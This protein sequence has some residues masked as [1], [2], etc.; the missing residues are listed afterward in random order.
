MLMVV[1]DC[2]PQLVENPVNLAYSVYNLD[3]IQISLVV[4]PP[5]GGGGGGGSVVY[6]L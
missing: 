3:W 6:N 4:F 5:W 1:W 2:C